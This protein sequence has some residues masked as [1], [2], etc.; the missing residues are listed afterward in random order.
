MDALAF[1]DQQVE[2]GHKVVITQEGGRVEIAVESN[3]H[4]AT[5][6]DEIPVRPHVRK[7]PKRPTRMNDSQV[8]KMKKLLRE[9][10]TRREVAKI[11][12][13]SLSTVTRYV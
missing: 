9:G 8:R 11:T 5:N 10:K 2:K 4:P 12:G 1:A 3:G 13:W 6:G 7:T